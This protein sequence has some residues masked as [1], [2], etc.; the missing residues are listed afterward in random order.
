MISHS[1]LFL[2]VSPIFVAILLVVAFMLLIYFIFV[3]VQGGR[4]FILRRQ[5]STTSSSQ[6]D[7]DVT[8][9]VAN[10]VAKQ[11]SSNRL[12]S[13]DA[14]RGL[15]IVAMIFAN[16]GA[17]RYHWFEHATWNGLHAADV[18]FPSFLWIMGVCIPI[19][20]K[21]QFAKNIP[22]H[23][24]LSSI[25]IVRSIIFRNIFQMIF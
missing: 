2:F 1:K 18:I 19:S 24:M 9:T 25:F 20:L 5:T 11:K 21:S 23:E 13:L 10:A 17:G 3:L 8:A 16:T 22:R 12:C 15:A 6:L 14:F 7:C 4:K